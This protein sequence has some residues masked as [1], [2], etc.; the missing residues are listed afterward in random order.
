VESLA[1]RGDLEDLLEAIDHEPTHE[2]VNAE[3]AFLAA[4]GGDCHS[5]VAARAEGGIV[6]AEILSADG[7]EIRAGEGAPAELARRLLAEASPALRAMFG[8]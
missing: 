4:L 7:S 6:R 3:R 2:A 1:G 8:R 5:A